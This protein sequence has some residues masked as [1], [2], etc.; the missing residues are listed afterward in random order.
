AYQGL[1]AEQLEKL[2]H[3]LP[4]SVIAE[5]AIPPDDLKVVLER[6]VVPALNREQAGEL[7]ARVEIVG[8]LLKKGSQSRLIFMAGFLAQ[9]N[10]RSQ[11]GSLGT[12]GRSSRDAIERLE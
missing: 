11:A 12:L 2:E 3:R 9:G 5:R 6:F 10:F 8:C 1:I 7:E 4:R